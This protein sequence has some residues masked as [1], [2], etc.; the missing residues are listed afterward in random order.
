MRALQ[1]AEYGGSDV[2]HVAEAEE[3]HA[4]EGQIR[5]AVRAVAV[6]P[7]EWQIRSGAMQDFMPVELPHI[8]GSD[9]AGVVDEV[10]D[11]VSGVSAGD[12]VFGSAVGAGSAQ[13]AVV[14]A[15]APMPAD[16]GFAE[17]AG[18]VTAAETAV[19]GLDLLG[20]E[21]ETTLVVNGAAG[22]VGSAVV[23]LALHRGATVIGTAS[24]VNHDYLRS[25]GAE[26]V[27]YGDG[28]VER[29]R[30]RAPDGVDVAFDVAGHG[31]APALIELVGRPEDVVTIADFEAG[32]LG[33]QVTSGSDGRSWQALALAAELFE[34]GRFTL[35]VAQAFPLA[36]GA[37]AHR[38]S[39]DGHVRGKLVLLVDD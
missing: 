26:P 2:L 12:Q 22:G 34:Q 13:Y 15:W 38:I 4:G 18:F 28:L 9:V 16:L 6:N 35:P 39:Q 5:V 21:A 19:R 24:P 14:H 17:A 37:A 11:G 36:D 31:A 32:R 27:T 25:L 30:D 23:Q 1:F 8:P 10:G 29:V 7:I 20:V 33:V 3:P